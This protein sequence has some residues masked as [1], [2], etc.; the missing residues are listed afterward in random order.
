[1]DKNA[2]VTWGWASELEG[3]ITSRLMATSA[4]LRAEEGTPEREVSDKKMT[5]TRQVMKDGQRQARAREMQREGELGWRAVLLLHF[6]VLFPVGM[7]PGYMSFT[8][9]RF[10]EM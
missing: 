9:L 3:H 4:H 5:G 10:C 2:A 1:M 8:A 6:L 7:R